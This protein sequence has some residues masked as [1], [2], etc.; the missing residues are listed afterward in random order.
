MCLLTCSQMTLQITFMTAL[1]YLL[2][3][4]QAQ[5]LSSTSSLDLLSSTSTANLHAF[6]ASARTIMTCILAF[7]TTCHLFPANTIALRG[8]STTNYRRTEESCTTW[9]GLRLTVNYRAFFAKADVASLA[10]LVA[11]AVELF[12]T[13]QL[14]RMIFSKRGGSESTADLITKML[15]AASLLFAD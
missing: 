12:V 9:T 13:S 5:R 7:M 4:I 15:S 14:T 10:T 1:Q 8:Q 3:F 11:L 6:I 2:T